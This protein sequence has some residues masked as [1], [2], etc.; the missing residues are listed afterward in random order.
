MDL[1]EWNSCNKRQRS[2]SINGNY[3][4]LKPV[5]L[6]KSL[7]RELFHFIYPSRCL[8][9]DQEIRSIL[10]HLCERCSASL[11]MAYHSKEEKKI[12]CFEHESAA[13]ELLKRYEK[14]EFKNLGQLIVSL[15]VIKFVNMRWE[16]PDLVICG[17]KEEIVLQKSNVC[18]RSLAKAFAKSL[19]VSYIDLLKYS[20]SERVYD[21]QG[22][23]EGA[24]KLKQGKIP[25]EG[26]KILIIQ[27][28]ITPVSKMYTNLLPKSCIL[29]FL[30]EKKEIF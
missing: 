3:N 27:D 30:S 15:M 24:V 20:V 5:M 28:Q 26:K 4:S 18:N 11:I 16:I 8:Y 13:K 29:T 19:G 9:C 12:Y 22:R 17:V 1:F 6:L 14:T 21:K 7:F 10:S 2:L 23:L 25:M